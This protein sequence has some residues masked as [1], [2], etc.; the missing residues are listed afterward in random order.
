MIN[1][2]HT[3]ADF[4]VHRP[5]FFQFWET[6]VLM[7][8]DVLLHF[9]LHHDTCESHQKSCD[10]SELCTRL[11]HIGR[12]DLRGYISVCLSMKFHSRHFMMLVNIV[13]L[14]LIFSSHRV[15]LCVCV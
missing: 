4:H 10:F 11:P 12:E 6:N 3:V 8:F 1:T 15:S 13:M 7:F 5:Y 9:L 14:I 2:N